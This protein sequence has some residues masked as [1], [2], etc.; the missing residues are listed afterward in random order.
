M[1]VRSST[2]CSLSCACVRGDLKTGA[3]VAH[4]RTKGE[5]GCFFGL[6]GSA[7]SARFR[8]TERTNQH[9]CM[10]PFHSQS[11]YHDDKPISVICLRVSHFVRAVDWFLCR[12]GLRVVGSLLQSRAEQS[13]TA[14][15]ACTG[16]HARQDDA[17]YSHQS[18]EA[19]N[20]GGWGKCPLQGRPASLSPFNGRCS[21]P[22]CPRAVRMCSLCGSGSV[23][24]GEERRQGNL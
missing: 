6:C 18:V 8:P 10:V 9:T 5:A 13:S 21:P 20:A 16:Q 22:E 17:K 3:R 23:G 1:P 7:F 24:R 11:V 14:Q 12:R 4:G 19:R 15:I 2:R